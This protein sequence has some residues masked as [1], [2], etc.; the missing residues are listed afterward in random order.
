MMRARRKRIEQARKV[1]RRARFR[2]ERVRMQMN[3]REM[4]WMTE[5]SGMVVC[6]LL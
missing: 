1:V 6:A 4:S 5:G 3:G 2:R